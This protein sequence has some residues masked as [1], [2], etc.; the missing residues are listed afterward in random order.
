VYEKMT[1]DSVPEVVQVEGTQRAT[2][3]VTWTGHLTS[4]FQELGLA[5]PYYTHV[6]QMLKQ[7]G[8]VEQLKRGGG[9]ALSQWRLVREPSE[10]AFKV[11]ASRKK[12]RQGSFAGLEQQMRDL[13]KRVDALEKR[14]L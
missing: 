13:S 7:M 4:L 5:T 12:P 9:A 8:C 3:F 10:D 1:A 6:M 11:A 14:L 2:G